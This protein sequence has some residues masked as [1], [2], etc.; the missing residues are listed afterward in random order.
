MTSTTPAEVREAADRMVSDLVSTAMAFMAD[1]ATSEDVAR[2]KL[3]IVDELARLTCAVGEVESAL[4]SH[5][6]AAKACPFNGPRRPPRDEPCPKCR[7]TAT[8]GCGPEIRTAFDVVRRAR[9]ALNT[10]EA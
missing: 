3:A 4:D 7:A 8:E 10:K 2:Q 6:A 5:D 1:K 9:T